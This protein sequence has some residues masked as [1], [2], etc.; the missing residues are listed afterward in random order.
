MNK[1]K[2]FIDHVANDKLRHNLL[3]DII[4]PSVI[5]LLSILCALLFDKLILGTWIGVVLC[6]AF[7]VNIEY[8]QK[9]TGKGQFD[10]MDAVW[11]SWSA[12]RTGL[13]ISIVYLCC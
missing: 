12:I 7:H 5:L 3:G 4:N 1:L 2:N 10:L 8:W 13:I 11:G 6:I 9:R